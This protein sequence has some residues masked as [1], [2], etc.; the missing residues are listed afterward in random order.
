MIEVALLRAMLRK[1]NYRSYRNYL[2]ETDLPREAI[3]ILK[4]IDSWYLEHV[5]EPSVEDIANTT[6]GTG[7]QNE[8]YLKQL[9]RSM[10][11]EA[12]ND[13][14][15]ILLERLRKKSMLGRLTVLALDA[16]EGRKA[17]QD[18]VSFA[19]KLE[20]P[21]VQRVEYVTD[22]LEEILN[23]GVKMK[24][25]RWRLDCLNKSLGS[26]RKGDFMFLFARPETG[27]TSFLA[28]EATYMAQQLKDD[29]GPI[30]WVNFEEQGKKVKLRCYQ[31]SLNATLVKLL[32]NPG[33]ARKRYQENTKDK[34]RIFDS[35]TAYKARIEALC[36]QEKPSLLIIDPIDKVQGF[37]A[38]REDL[39]MGAVYQWARE[40]AKR[41]CPVIGTSQA[42]GEAEG[43]KYLHMGHVSNARTAKQAEADAILGIG[44][45][46]D[47]GFE[48]VRYFNIS[49]NKLL[50]DEDT[51]PSLRHGR[52]EVLL[53]AD[54]ARYEDIP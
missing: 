42:S 39:V 9:L 33:E 34:I 28:S 29:S 24:G 53:Q 31:A 17:V 20:E 26:L 37:M 18:V 6:L 50:G 3:P 44:K 35:A 40:L 38:D 30:L 10:S 43:E 1:E 4:A 5:E 19:K 16:L 51:D 15:R 46:H 11:T 52:F 12:G 27:K 23:T 45:T 13:T 47:L 25:L 8:E 54:T 2:V 7:G 41:Y 32:Q 48:K 22:D 49:K 36:E 14:V 21:V